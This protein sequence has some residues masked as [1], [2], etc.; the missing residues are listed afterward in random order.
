M[1]E[2]SSSRSRARKNNWLDVDPCFKALGTTELARRVRY[3]EFV[4]QV[5]P[6][7]ELELIRSALQRGQLTGASRFVE[8]I[9]HITGLRI[10]SRGQGR[11]AKNLD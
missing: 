5:A 7:G 10:I 1:V 3:K 11:P 6:R 9:E 4:E 2:L 8:E